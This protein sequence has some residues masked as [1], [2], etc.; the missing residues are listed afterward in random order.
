MVPALLVLYGAVLFVNAFVLL[1]KVEAKSAGPV[2]IAI[3]IIGILIGLYTGIASLL[4]DASGFVAALLIVFAVTFVLVGVM[5]MGGLDGRA[6]GYYCL[7]G[8]IICLMWAYGFYVVVGSM[9]NG[10]FSIIWAILFAMFAGNLA[11]A[12]PWARI[13]AYSAIFTAFATLVI[14]GYLLL[15][16]VSLP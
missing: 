8:V 7:W 9:A 3:G 14:P 15:I 1:G 16:G 4:G 6:V 13:T 10:T 11:F 2:N 12:K 5:F